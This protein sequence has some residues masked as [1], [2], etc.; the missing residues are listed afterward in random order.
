MW[1]NCCE[2]VSVGIDVDGHG[3]AEMN[4]EKKSVTAGAAKKR[5]EE[6]AVIDSS[7]I[8]GGTTATILRYLKTANTDY[9][10]M[11]NGGWGCGKTYYIEHA[12]KDAVEASQHKMLYISLHG[13]ATIE[14]VNVQLALG[15]IAG[16]TARPIYEVSS[17][18]SVGKVLAPLADTWWG[19]IGLAVTA[20]FG[21]IKT[22]KLPAFGK[23]LLI[24]VDDVERAAGEKELRCILGWLYENYI[25]HGFHLLFVCDESKKKEDGEWRDCKEKYIRRTIEFG[26]GHRDLLI[27]FAKSR[28][29]E[30]P[31]VYDEIAADYLRFVDG[32]KLV[33]LRTV[34][35][36]IDG[37][38]ELIGSVEDE[39]AK[40]YVKFLFKNIAPLY[41]AMAEGDLCAVD[42]EAGSWLFELQNVRWFHAEEEKRKDASDEELKACGFVDKYDPLF[43]GMYTLMPHV[44]KF[45]VSGNLDASK[46][47]EEIRH[48]FEC[49]GKPEMIAYGKLREYWDKDEEPLLEVLKEVVNYLEKGSYSLSDIVNIYS[50]FAG[51]KRDQYV[52]SWPY[53][54]DLEVLF[55]RYLKI[56]IESSDAKPTQD[57]ITE[58]RLHHR[59]FVKN[60]SV[61]TGLWKRIDEFYEQCIE[62][63]NQERLESF[64]AAL[65]SG[66]CFG[67]RSFMTPE[68]GEW[69]LFREIEQFNHFDDV[70]LLPVC[71]L[72]FLQCTLR[73]KIMQIV[74]I[75]F[76]EGD[77]VIPMC[78]L[79][80]HLKTA[81]ASNMDLKESKKARLSELADALHGASAHI[82]ATMDNVRRDAFKQEYSAELSEFGLDAGEIKGE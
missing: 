2:P 21:K 40:K 62:K 61:A 71:G 22:R 58:M 18:F 30:L 47:M 52:S 15:L 33:N 14:E 11:L 3:C 37:L 70:V 63:D 29:S 55:N 20:A 73:H 49:D 17:A 34:A 59:H 60:D 50:C 6:C 41:H 57:E 32:L 46:I 45:V 69:K 75:G 16:E 8:Y 81:I 5:A 27:Q 42:A 68:N 26:G 1:K 36:V 31:W 78:R 9:A 51:I 80:R 4:A 54:M 72:H 74:N 65:K 79:E 13:V 53:E 67:A 48:E 35:M 23:E 66:D 43:D 12:L 39:F 19:R 7:G 64:F 77:Q 10:V 44:L 24:V 76:Y 82:I 38:A 28:L 56:K 25:K